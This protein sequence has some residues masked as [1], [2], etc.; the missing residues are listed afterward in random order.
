MQSS[1]LDF[2]KHWQRLAYLEVTYCFSE[3]L[4][5]S[6]LST[7]G[8]HCPRLRFVTIGALHPESKVTS[9]GFLALASACTDLE[10]V[11]LSV[12]V[13]KGTET[14]GASPSI[15]LATSTVNQMRR[16]CRGLRYIEFWTRPE[17]VSDLL[18]SESLFAPLDTFG[19]RF[20]RTESAFD[21]GTSHHPHQTALFYSSG[22]GP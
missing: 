8:V 14:K 6:L 1:V 4:T 16:Q 5:D 18:Q 10:N 20:D 9:N 2:V 11:H 15:R 19:L 17:G 13:E 22:I 12:Y 3:P 7:L 21:L